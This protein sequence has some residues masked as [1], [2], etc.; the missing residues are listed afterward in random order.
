L[1][2]AGGPRQIPKK[3]KGMGTP[4]GKGGVFQATL[5]GSMN[6]CPSKSVEERW[7]KGNS[8]ANPNWGRDRGKNPEEQISG[9]TD[10]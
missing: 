3:G 2:V 9:S 8:P 6:V 7:Q 5:F 1:E 10:H 4:D